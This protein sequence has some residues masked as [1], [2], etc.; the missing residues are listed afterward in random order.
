ME[1]LNGFLKRLDHHIQARE[2]HSLITF[3]DFLQ[4]MT[5]KPGRVI[6]S[7]FQVFH[8]MVRY[9][10]GEGLQEYPDDPES[11]N[12]VSYDCRDLFVEGA[13]NPFFA[14]RLFAN[15]FINHIES[16]RRGAQQNKIYIFEGPP[17]CGKSTFLNNLLRKFEE[18]ANTEEGCRY[19]VVWRLNCRALGGYFDHESSPLIGNLF[20]FLELNNPK[21][22]PELGLNPGKLELG[23]QVHQADDYLEIPCPSHDNPILL[24]PKQ[25]R[26]EFLDDLLKN[27]EFKW[28]LF[29]QKEYEW[30]FRQNPCT[31]CSSLIQALLD[32]LPQP[33]NL[34]NM[35][36]TRKYR[37]NRRLG[38]G[39]SVFNPGDK[40]ARDFILSNKMLQERLN[41]LLKDSNL[42]QYLFSRYAKTNNG[43]YAL[44]DIKLHNIER[45]NAL[46]NI[47]SEGVHKV[48]D[49]EENVNSLFFALMNPEDKSNIEGTQSFSD[50]I[51]YIKINYVL[52]LNTEVEIYRSI[53]GRHIENNFLP[54]VLKNFARVIISSRLNI[55]SEALDRWITAP[56]D[57][58]HYCDENMLLLKMEMYRGKIPTWLSEEDRKLLDAPLRRSIIAESEKEG[59]RGFSGRDSIKIFS[60]FYSTYAR[61]DKLITMANLC[62]FFEKVQ[63][64]FSKFIPEGFLNALNNMYNYTIVQEVKE[65]LYYYNEKQIARD[66]MNYIFAVNFE[67]DT[68]ARCPYTGDR[69]EISEDFLGG[70]ENRILGSQS[71]ELR[72]L[73]F[74]QDT[75]KEYTTRTLTQEIML[76]QKSIHETE[77]YGSLFERYVYNI[78]EKVLEPFLENENFNRA[79]KDYGTDLF[80]TYDKRIREDISFLIGNLMK[81]FRYTEQGA[82]E[83]CIYVIDN[84]LARSF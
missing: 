56:E 76:E 10:V 28:N 41:A 73:A 46:H 84:D 47:I 1:E 19:E 31:I 66:V 32:K 64:K 82:R 2:E 74:R 36:Y 12:F 71:G 61:D 54:R 14:D 69:L 77:L 25:H 50:R 4:I 3:E 39:I 15:R 6:R 43:I 30:V 26:R 8:D 68:T 13:D 78:K 20:K 18:Y 5:E 9:Y 57:Y 53:F 38:E 65:A 7:I 24:I 80:R 21:E 75:Q 58:A 52:D 79:M 59:L 33:T 23:E 72:R 17:G 22:Q 34:F 60:D 49:I 67:L 16:M 81:K 44:M 42:V 70:I 11:I 51:D 37:F 35:V 83:V 55:K 40:H 48:D 27:D 63:I 45:I 29:T 62:S